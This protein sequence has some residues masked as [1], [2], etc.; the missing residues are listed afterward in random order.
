MPVAVG[1]LVVTLLVLLVTLPLVTTPH[2][3][4]LLDY[5]G[6]KAGKICL[7]L[8][9]SGLDQKSADRFVSSKNKK[10]CRMISLLLR[11]IYLFCSLDICNISAAVHPS[12]VMNGIHVGQPVSGFL[13]SHIFW[14]ITCY[15]CYLERGG[16]L[17][18]YSV[19]YCY[20]QVSGAP[21]SYIQSQQ[22]LLLI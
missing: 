16:S 3:R 20:P 10:S 15:N 8:K 5:W 1:Q 2:T 9:M 19:L 4:L 6:Y 22:C 18:K 7:K 14:C 12:F 21:S 11:Y 13:H 17:H